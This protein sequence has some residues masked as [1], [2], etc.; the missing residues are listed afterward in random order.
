MLGPDMTAE[1]A[2]QSTPDTPLDAPGSLADLFT[3]GRSVNHFAG[4]E[5]DP[6]EVYAAYEV[7]KWG[8]TAMNASPS[9]SPSS[10]AARPG[11]LW[12]RT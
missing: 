2:Q 8:P 11:R 12:R 4:G 5:V 6:A 3:E 1:A 10:L 9:G 7:I